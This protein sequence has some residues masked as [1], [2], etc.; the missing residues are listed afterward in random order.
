METFCTAS[1]RGAVLFDGTSTRQASPQ[2]EMSISA[3]G[4]ARCGRVVDLRLAHRF[5]MAAGY[6]LIGSDDAFALLLN[7]LDDRKYIA[8]FGDMQIARN[9]DFEHQAAQDALDMAQALGAVFTVVDG[10]VKCEVDGALTTG[11]TYVDAAMR[12][13][14]LHQSQSKKALDAGGPDCEQ[15]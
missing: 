6:A 8:V 4:D 14:V 10:T 9:V 12:A 2:G 3:V 15:R 13:V 1:P 7:D 11:E 5:A